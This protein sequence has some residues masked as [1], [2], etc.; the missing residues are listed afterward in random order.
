MSNM[1]YA[2]RERREEPSLGKKLIATLGL[3]VFFTLFFIGLRLSMKL[4]DPLISEDLITAIPATHPWCAEG[5]CPV[6]P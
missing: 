6:A 4:A 3:I 2:P 1:S 5:E